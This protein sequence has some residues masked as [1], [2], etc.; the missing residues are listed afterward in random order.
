MY[1]ETIYPLLFI[2]ISYLTQ[3]IKSYFYAN[4]ILKNIH[5]EKLY[6]RLFICC[7]ETMY[8][9]QFIWRQYFRITEVYQLLVMQRLLILR[10]LDVIAFLT[11]LSLSLFTASCYTF[12]PCLK[13][14]S[15]KVINKTINKSY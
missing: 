8:S 5:R 7:L 2:W 15:L 14:K 4:N 13:L 3:Y 11:H 9:R 6:T 10:Q 1:L 12:F